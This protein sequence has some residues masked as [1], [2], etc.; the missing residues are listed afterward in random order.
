M[1]FAVVGC[2][3]A[4]AQDIVVPDGYTVVDSLVYRPV[5]GADSTLV[6]K[7][8]WNVMPSRS[9]GDA[10]EVSLSQSSQIKSALDAQVS[11][12]S[13]RSISGYRVRIFFDNGQNSRGESEA[14]MKRF[15]SRYHGIPAYRTRC[16]VQGRVQYLRAAA[17]PLYSQQAARDREGG[18]GRQLRSARSA[19]G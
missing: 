13:S 4:S 7:S 12:N 11:T 16:P 15:E 5:A 8:V 17:Q 14:V 18:S 3:A 19:C 10:A 2:L 1:F 9:A 6:G